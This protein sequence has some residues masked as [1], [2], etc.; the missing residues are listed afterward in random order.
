MHLDLFSVLFVIDKCFKIVVF[1]C[2]LTQILTSRFMVFYHI[3][4]VW[5]KKIELQIYTR[6]SCHILIGESKVICSNSD[7]SMLMQD[8]VY[9]M[10]K[11]SHTSRGKSWSPFLF[12]H[13]S[14]ER[15]EQILCIE[16]L[17]TSNMQIIR[18][19]SKWEINST[20]RS[21]QTFK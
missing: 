7:C 17:H 4:N 1:V 5:K 11:C 9:S 15:N 21:S 8:L 14:H 12:T 2:T 10:C 6:S 3:L 16:E 20:A 18:F 13:L 19:K